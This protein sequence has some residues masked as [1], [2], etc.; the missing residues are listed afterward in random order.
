MLN[1][2][3]HSA[4]STQHSPEAADYHTRVAA[5]AEPNHSTGKHCALEEE[6]ARGE[7]AGIQSGRA[8]ERTL[9]RRQI[10]REAPLVGAAAGPLDRGLPVSPPRRQPP[11][12]RFDDQNAGSL[13]TSRPQRREQRGASLWRQFVD[14]VR[15]EN[16]GA[17]PGFGADPPESMR[18]NVR[19]NDSVSQAELPVGPARFRDRP[20]MTVKPANRAHSRRDCQAGACSTRPATQ[21]DDVGDRAVWKSAAP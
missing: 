6:R 16:G 12:N 9:G 1:S 21:V 19:L 7:L 8:R 4:F 10:G 11:C 13:R 18:R 2:L 17:R 3:Q 14:G 20:R 5:P 15:G